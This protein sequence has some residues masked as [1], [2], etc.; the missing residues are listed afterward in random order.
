MARGAVANRDLF[1]ECRQLVLQRSDADSGGA[2]DVH[3]RL[4]RGQ[5]KPS[6]RHHVAPRR[7]FSGRAMDCGAAG[8]ARRPHIALEVRARV[9]AAGHRARA[10]DLFLSA[11][12]GTVRLKCWSAGVPSR[13]KNH[14]SAQPALW[15][16][17]AAL[18]CA[19][20]VWLFLQRVMIPYQMAEAT[21]YGR[22]RGNLSDLYPRWLGARE[23]LL[24]GRDP[25]G[26]EV[27]REIQV[28][29]YGRALDH[30][31][32]GDPK[33]QQ[34]FAY[35]VYVVFA[36]SPAVRLPFAL[37]QMWFSPLLILLTAASTLIWIRSLGWRNSFLAR[38]VVIVLALGSL[39][40]MQGLKLEQMSLLVAGFIAIAILFL[41]R[42]YQVG[43]G[44]VLALASMKPQL[45]ALL[46]VWL[47]LWT[48][49]DA[50]RRYRWAVSF[51]VGMAVQIAAGGWDL[52]HW[53]ARFWQ[54]AWEYRDYTAA[55]SVLEKWVGPPAGRTLEIVAFVLLMRLCWI[56]RT[57]AAKTTA[58]ARTTSVVLAFTVLLI[59]TDSVYN[60]VL[61]IPALLVL[62]EERHALWRRSAASR[63]L[64]LTVAMLVAWPWITSVVLAGLSF[65]LPQETVEAYWAIPF[66]TA[67]LIPVGVAA[68]M[69]VNAS[70]RSFAEPAQGSTS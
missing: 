1:A 63:L 3:F 25:Y 36:L 28:G 53:I 65:I 68:L 31:R 37:V 17:V 35:P 69:L 59:P 40:V 66:W 47:G 49:G 30:S 39:A 32:A 14:A 21:A 23:L 43:A 27:T 55:I 29:Y 56:E 2:V 64:L 6:G 41:I 33:D 38:I 15:M 20:G 67:L 11:L 12:P 22:P 13:M 45:V 48:L 5:E 61:L 24:H 34:G 44:I 54:A 7:H 58:F 9:D 51:V 10:F 60:Q 16:V 4:S 52:P 26:A 18:V 19:A 50:R 62:F 57:W 8:C 46:L 42:D 70:Q